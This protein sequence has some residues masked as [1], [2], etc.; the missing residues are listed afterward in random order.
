M[1]KIKA[2]FIFKLLFIGV[3]LSGVTAALVMKFMFS[4]ST[5]TIPDFSGLPLETAQKI[6]GRSGIEVK[7]E[8]EVDS[9]LYEKGYVVSQDMPPRSTIKKGRAIYVVISKGSR[10]V[11]VPGIAGSLTSK[12]V[13]DLKNAFLDAGLETAVS[14]F[15]APQDI[16]ISQ[17]PPDGENVP[18]GSTVNILKSTGPKKF[19]FMM[20]DFKGKNISDIYSIMKKYELFIS[21]LTVQDNDN[22]DSGSVIDQSP[23]AGYKINKESPVSFIISKKPG[24]TA[25]RKRLIKI[26][27]RQE[28]ANVPSLV[29]INVLSL[30]GSE[31]VYN[32]MTPPDKLINLSASVRGDALVQIFSGTQVIKEIEFKT[33][34]AQ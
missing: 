10:M 33:E 21:D 26:S 12:A 24:D 13:I 5:I 34:N 32:E 31:T 18:S 4:I 11:V 1:E 15:V 22:V 16:I 23:E 8:N 6:A 14:S 27:Y 17:S 2:S 19:D 29:K 3:F 25:L 7:V 9:N 20:P 30:N 28:K